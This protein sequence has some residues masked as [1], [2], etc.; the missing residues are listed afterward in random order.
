MK[1]FFGTDGVRGVAGRYPLDEITLRSLGQALLLELDRPSDRPPRIVIGRDTRESGPDIEA[2]LVRGIEEGGGRAVRGGILT[3]PAVACVTRLLGCEA[4]IV[5]SASHNP[6]HDNGVK[7]FSGEG[8]KL[9]DAVEAAIERR[10][11]SG[12]D[13]LADRETHAYSGAAIDKSDLVEGGRDGAPPTGRRPGDDAVDLGGRYLDWLRSCLEPRASFTGWRIVL[14]CANGAASELGPA[15]FRSLGAEV[16]A[17]SASPDGRNINT[18][19][20]AL[21]PG[22]LSAEVKRLRAHIGFAFDGDADRCLLIDPTGRVLDGDHVLYLAARDLKKAGRL[23]SG[24]VVATVMANLWLEEALAAEGIRMLRAP[25]GDKYVLEEMKSGGHL[26]GGEQSGHIIFLERATTGDG[27]LT[28]LLLL[29]LL[30]RTRFDLA[31]WAEKIVPC[32]QVL[33][34][35]MVRER[36]SLEDHPVIG[37]AI[38]EETRRMEGAGRIL[39]RYSGTEPKARIMV[40]GKDHR[41]VEECAARLERVIAREIGRDPA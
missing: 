36:P 16:T 18:G 2:A 29:D 34:N 3:T 6:Y 4:G 26:L 41:A 32:P 17:L 30:R 35:V 1:R 37:P 38:R 27:L 39:V 14:D 19:C 7:I 5:V 21:H 22:G 28:A 24:T 15:L 8:F 10:I 13:P 31:G 25:V 9:P 12:G 33:V 23:T 11:L 20:G 40:E